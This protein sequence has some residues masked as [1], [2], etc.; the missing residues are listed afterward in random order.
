MP[1]IVAFSGTRDGRSKLPYE[2]E[3][4]LDTRGEWTAYWASLHV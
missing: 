2:V 1:V 3:T 4:V